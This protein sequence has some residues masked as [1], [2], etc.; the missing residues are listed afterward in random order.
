[1]AA[2]AADALAPTPAGVP[3]AVPPP[4]AL[5]FPT[6]E[7]AAPIAS[8]SGAPPPV[9]AGVLAPLP[10][11]GVRLCG[12]CAERCERPVETA[13]GQSRNCRNRIYVNQIEK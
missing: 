1:M 13:P 8:A 11:P 3:V 6:K 12:L 5:P 4:G 9:F 7:A 2:G 10:P